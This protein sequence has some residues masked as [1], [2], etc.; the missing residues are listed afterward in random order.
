MDTMEAFT[1]KVFFFDICAIILLTVIMFTFLFRKLAAGTNSGF[2]KWVVLTLLLTAIADFTSE[3][4]GVAF[5]ATPDMAWCKEGI[6]YFYFTFRNMHAPFHVLLIASV[7]HSWSVIKKNRVL[8]SVGMIPLIISELTLYS[9]LFTHKV[10]T[11]GQDLSYIRGSQ[12]SIIYFCGGIYMAMG[13]SML[14][15]YRKLLRKDKFFALISMYPLNILAIL[16]QIL[17]PGLL[18]E[19]LAVSMTSLL[20]SITLFNPQE[21]KDP[22]LDVFNYRGFED[23]MKKNYF[24][25]KSDRIILVNIINWDSI[26]AMLGNE[27]VTVLLMRMISGFQKIFREHK[28]N[29]N[30]YYLENGFFGFIDEKD[31]LEAIKEVAEDMDGFLLEDLSLN[32]VVIQLNSSI[33]YFDM[34]EQFK[35]Y[36]EFYSFSENFRKFISVSKGACSIQEVM[37]DN[38]FALRNNLDS[39]IDEAISK[40]SFTMFYQPIFSVSTNSYVGAEALIRLK[41]EKYGYVSPAKF[42]AAAVNSGAIHKIWDFILDDV[43]RFISENELIVMGFEKIN[44]NVSGIQLMS[45]GFAE[46]VESCLSRYKVNPSMI[47]FEMTESDFFNPQPLF[48]RNMRKLSEYGISF[49]IDDFGTGNSN[50]CRISHLPISTVKLDRQFI[51]MNEIEGSRSILLNTIKMLKDLGLKILAEAVEDERTVEVLKNLD[52]DYLQGFYFMK[53]LSKEDFLLRFRSYIPEDAFN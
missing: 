46:R 41:S 10:F 20:C 45:A 1:G 6:L 28:V 49:A 2:L 35:K 34:M 51:S 33:C 4:F 7:T 17:F 3:L 8:L 40:K 9:N 15:S 50:I 48:I 53:P 13:I 23:E 39:I 18:I 31:S 16:L 38:D 52:C 32:R 21:M 24:V 12:I 14:A 25:G 36:E 37:E 29:V 44:L 27:N 22:V 11:L 19:M 42:I 26:K 47:A 30:I 43:C 5:P